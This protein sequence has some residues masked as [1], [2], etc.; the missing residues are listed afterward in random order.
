[1]LGGLVTL[2]LISWYEP[3]CDGT[4]RHIIKGIAE[5]HL[6]LSI[7]YRSNDLLQDWKTHKRSTTDSKRYVTH[8]SP[9]IFVL[10]FNDLMAK[11]EI[12][13]RLD[14]LASYPVMER[15]ICKGLIVESKVGSSSKQRL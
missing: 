3:L 1:M 15:N 9:A 12:D 11:E 10:A 4:G 8:F 13:V 5:E 6:L 2:G 14:M 7:R